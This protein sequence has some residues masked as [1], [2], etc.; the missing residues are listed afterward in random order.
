MPA[1]PQPRTR[2]LVWALALAAATIAVLGM[3]QAIRWYDHPV[4][5]ILVTADREVSSVGMPTW[6]GLAQGLGYPD[7]VLA[8]NG[9]DLTA[10][11]GQNSG[12]SLWDEAVEAAGRRGA[13]SVHLR[14]LTRSGIRELDVRIDRLEPAVWWLYGGGNVFIG[15]LYVIAALTALSASPRGALARAFGKYALL[16]SLFLF[17]FFDEHTSHTLV[18]LHF[19]AFGWAPIALLGLTLRLPDDVSVARRFPALLGILDAVGASAG[20][21]LAVSQMLGR[22]TY[23]FRSKWTFVFAACGLLSVAVLLGRFL[24]ATGR[25]RSILR[26]VV[27][28]TTAPY[29]VICAGIIAASQSPRGASITFFA[30]PALAL[31]PLASVVAFAR[32]DLW[33]SRALLSRVVTRTVTGG[34]VCAASACLGAA[35]AASLGVPIRA[36]LAAA[37]AGAA[38][39]APLLYFTLRAVD[40]TFFPAVAEYKPTIEQLSED[41]TL[42]SAPGEIASAVERTVRRWLPCDRVE[43]IACDHVD[44]ADPEMMPTDELTIAATFGGRTLGMLRVGNKRGGALF[45]TEDIDLLQTIANQAALA[46]AYARNYAELESRRRQ[47]A[48]AWQVERLAL[49]ETLAA[50]VA[51]EIRYPINFFRSVFQRGPEGG[52][53]EADEIDVGFEEVERLERLVAGLRR[54]VGYHVERKVVPVRELANHAEVLLRDRLGGRVLVV[55]V[56][57]TIALRCDPDQV[58]QV[59]VNLVSNALDASGPEGQVGVDWTTTD[60]AAELCVWDDGPGFLGEASALF[61]PWFTTKPQGTGLGLAITQR[62]VRA[63]NWRIDALREGKKTRFVVTIPH[64]DV[65]EPSPE[66][67]LT[68]EVAQ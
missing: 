26:I 20:A 28:S 37:G 66:I 46:V 67:V 42:I 17:T 11:H 60:G 56:P 65:V 38:A 10:R 9:L 30:I 49:V 35:F 22:E 4:A 19:V 33:G 40:R 25:R 31:A 57:E 45:T 63:H 18:P 7:Q 21:F 55:S 12:V 48:A 36:A 24:L 14:V 41:L 2:L 58:R 16:A 27:Q 53:L 47:Q 44:P 8:V 43:F 52:K 61:A 64:A 23:E 62:I 54:L 50:E 1:A 15:A 3:H 6:D 5:G 68:Q 29:A 51:H 34:F 32:N 59:F 39:A 13:S